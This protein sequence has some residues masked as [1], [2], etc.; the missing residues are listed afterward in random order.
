MEKALVRLGDCGQCWVQICVQKS[1]AAV[2]AGCGSCLLW[3]PA[4]TKVAKGH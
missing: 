4:D 2:G 3:T 1:C